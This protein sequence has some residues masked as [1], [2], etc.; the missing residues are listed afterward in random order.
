M[1]P[2]QKQWN[3]IT[4]GKT[5]N[6]YVIMPPGKLTVWR[7]KQSLTSGPF[8]SIIKIR[9][10]LIY[11]LTIISVGVCAYTFCETFVNIIIEFSYKLIRIYHIT[12]IRMVRFFSYVSTS[13]FQLSIFNL[14]SSV[15]IPEVTKAKLCW[16]PMLQ[17]LEINCCRGVFSTLWNIY[18]KGFW[19]NMWCFARFVTNCTI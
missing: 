2:S 14:T 8:C 11:C 12:L 10:S 6:Y 17:K 1:R 4:R 7:M 16:N 19:Q 15:N 5:V 18:D 13:V 9:T 3:R